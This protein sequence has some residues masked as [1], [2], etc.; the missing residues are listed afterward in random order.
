MVAGFIDDF[1]IQC[2]QASQDTRAD[3]NARVSARTAARWVCSTKV[4]NRLL[5]KLAAAKEISGHVSRQ[6]L[7]VR[8]FLI[9]FHFWL[10]SYV[11]Q[12]A[13]PKI[14]CELV[15]IQNALISQATS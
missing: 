5:A 10:K 14:Q 6:Y 12:S 2:R 15:R 1:G 13:T 7:T 3:K 4:Q 8:S 11:V 9:Q